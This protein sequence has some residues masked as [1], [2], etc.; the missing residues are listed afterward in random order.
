[1]YGSESESI[2]TFDLVAMIRPPLDVTLPV[3]LVV[4]FV[5]QDMRNQHGL[6]DVINQRNDPVLVPTDIKN[7]R[8]FPRLRVRRHIRLAEQRL[9]VLKGLPACFTGQLE[10]ILKC[11]SM[12]VSLWLRFIKLPEFLSANDVHDFTLCEVQ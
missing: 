10:P 12:L 1:M 11:F 4:L 2:L 7:R 3:I 6:A 5:V 9:G 8:R